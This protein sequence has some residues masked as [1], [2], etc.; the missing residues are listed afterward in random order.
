MSVPTA[1]NTAN[2][3][4]SL[5]TRPALRDAGRELIPGMFGDVDF[6]N[7]LGTLIQQMMM[8]IFQSMTQAGAAADADRVRTAGQSQARR[9]ARGTSD[10]NLARDVEFEGNNLANMAAQAA[11]SRAFSPE[12]ALEIARNLFPLAT[13]P[14]L[15]ARLGAVGDI[16]ANVSTSNIQRTPPRPNPLASA[17]GFA[18]QGYG[19]GLFNPQR[20][21]QGIL[22][23]GAGGG[24]ASSGPLPAVVRFSS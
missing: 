13:S 20:I 12:G 15:T 22:S 6:L 5:P 3:T 21:T 10:P 7:R 23:G 16:N 9:Q 18:A 19:A 4:G 2:Y 1:Y 17:L 14:A 8:N 24:D 11:I